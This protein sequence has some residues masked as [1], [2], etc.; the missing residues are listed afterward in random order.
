MVLE[1]Y[2]YKAVCVCEESPGKVL[3]EIT[4]CPLGFLHA[5]QLR[6]PLQGM[7]CLVM[8]LANALQQEGASFY[9]ARVKQFFKFFS[10]TEFLRSPGALKEHVLDRCGEQDE[11]EALLIHNFILCLVSQSPESGTDLLPLIESMTEI[12][13]KDN[14]APSRYFDLVV[15]L[16][17][18]YAGVYSSGA[19]AAGERLPW[20]KMPLVPVAAE[21]RGSKSLPFVKEKGGYGSV[22]E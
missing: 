17:R 10:G 8:L 4:K 12:V 2:L 3:R 11:E 5:L 7:V 13:K 16:L 19:E 9:G 14:I 22:D 18:C 6:Q 21:I 20:D 1:R 15:E